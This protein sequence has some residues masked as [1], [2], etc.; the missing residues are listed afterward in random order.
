MFNTLEDFGCYDIGVK[1]FFVAPQVLMHGESFSV[2]SSTSKVSKS[3]LAGCLLGVSIS[4]TSVF[5]S[6]L[7]CEFYLVTGGFG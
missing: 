3:I 5:S 7:F 6:M 2:K 4:V 1:K